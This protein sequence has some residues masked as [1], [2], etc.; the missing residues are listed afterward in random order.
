MAIN[1]EVAIAAFVSMSEMKNNST[2]IFPRPRTSDGTHVQTLQV[3][4]PII[5]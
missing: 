4:E 3:F 1:T 2:K 5:G